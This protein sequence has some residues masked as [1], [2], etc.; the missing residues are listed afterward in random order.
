MKESAIKE[1]LKICKD[2]KEGVWIYNK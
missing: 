1:F 2:E